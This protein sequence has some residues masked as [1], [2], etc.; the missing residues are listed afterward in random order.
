MKVKAVKASP[1]KAKKAVARKV[2]RNPLAPDR[3]R[4]LLDKLAEAYPDAECALHH[5]N[6]WELLVATVLSAQCTDARVNM[7]TPALFERFPTPADFAD[8]SLVQIEE[9]IRSTGFYHNKAKSLK[10]AATM[11]VTEFA[12]EVPQ[13]MEVLVRIPGVARKTANVVLGVAFGKG[14]GVVVDTHVLRLSRRLELT[15]ETQPVP[16]EQDLMKI[17]PQ[18]RWIAFSHELIQHGRRVCV[19]RKPRCADCGLE[20]ECYSGDKTWGSHP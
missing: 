5:R 20:P 9:M 10:G 7:V 14:V 16:V 17:L 19:A 8:A 2:R 18:D 15:K 3:I 1:A 11:L 12:S 4:F 13:T 6:A